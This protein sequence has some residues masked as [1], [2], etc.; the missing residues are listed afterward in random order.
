[1]YSFCK[2]FVLMIFV[3]FLH[4]VSVFAQVIVAEKDSVRVI[5]PTEY[6]DGLKK[7]RLNFRSFSRD[8]SQQATP[9]IKGYRK[10]IQKPYDDYNGKIIRNI[11][12]KTLDPFD[13]SISGES[14]ERINIFLRAG[15]S[16]HI[17]TRES[18][19]R[20]FLLFYENEPFDS[21]LVKES[22]RLIRRQSYTRDAAFVVKPI[23]NENDSVDIL[24]Y[25]LDR[26]SI[27][28]ALAWSKERFEIGLIEKNLLGLGHASL[29][30]FS[31]YSEQGDLNFYSEYFVP[32]I[33]NT[34]INA[35]VKY[36]ADEFK[37]FTRSISFERPFFS[38]VAK[39]AGGINFTE[40]KRSNPKFANDTLFELS[41]YRLHSQNFWA[42]RSF[43]I[44]RKGHANER[45]TRLIGAVR[46]YNLNYV[47]KSFESF[48][49]L[50]LF[51][52][53]E[54]SLATIGISKRNY[55]RDKFIFEYGI[56][57]DVPIGGAISFTG[58]YQFRNALSRYYV[59][60]RLSFGGYFRL[61]YLGANLE[62]GTFFRQT[63]AEQGALA[64]N[65]NYFSGLVEFGKWKFR[66]FLKTQIT[67]GLSRNANEQLT[68]N[69]FYVPSAYTSFTLAGKSRVLLTFQ[70]QFYAP[71]RIVGF[72]IAPF[73]IYSVGMV[74][75]QQSTFFD[76]PF[77]SQ[78]GLGFLVNN[79]NLVFNTFQVSIAFY[80]LMPDNTRNVFGV[81]PFKSTDFGFEGFDIG[82]PTPVGFN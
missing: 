41:T 44:H 45:V 25:E 50:G 76:N 8:R 80:P 58:G 1:M 2:F 64:F 54:L 82:M 39:W 77:Y 61:G 53:E 79:L 19:I 59:G 38:P 17:Q 35:E 3:L 15:N 75:Q 66:Q 48:D 20:G 33:S 68:L 28:P 31:R 24:I 23:D 47:E 22:E 5:E 72:R 57:E 63:R 9:F 65:V 43:R 18:V 62:Y 4:N 70:S 74:G 34:Y 51:S 81:N 46:F 56:T 67:I 10:L 71:Y 55:L 26:W 36:G 13:Y 78:F 12:I 30:T 37:N 40:Q 16:L 27:A 49:T 73:F 42:G 52:N 69:D 60:T 7:G 14:E 29:N 11:T 21:L 6:K 32:N